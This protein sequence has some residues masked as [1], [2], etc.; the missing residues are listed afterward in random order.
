MVCL[1]ESCTQC[2]VK[3]SSVASGV[4][5]FIFVFTMQIRFGRLLKFFLFISGRATIDTTISIYFVTGH[6]CRFGDKIFYS[7]EVM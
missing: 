4:V 1:D 2:T 3:L 6:Y 5:L 7:V